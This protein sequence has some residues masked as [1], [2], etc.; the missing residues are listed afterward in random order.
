VLAELERVADYLILV[1]GGR[2]QVA[3]EVDSLLSTHRILTGPASDARTHEELAV[4]HE[5][6]AEAQAHLL[7]RTSGPTDPVPPGWEAHPVS[8]EELVLA[9][10]REPSAAALSGPARSNNAAP[11]EVAR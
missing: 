4:V 11:T 6:R 1:S 10:L 9:Y 7:V 3:D 8:L 2:V 5:R